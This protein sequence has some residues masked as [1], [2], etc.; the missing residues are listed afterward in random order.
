MAVITLLV[1]RACLGF[2]LPGR[3]TIALLLGAPLGFV[4]GMPFPRG[5]RLVMQRSS[6]LGGREW[7]LHRYWHSAGSNPRHGD[8]IPNRSAGG[9]CLLLR[10]T[11]GSHVAGRHFHRGPRDCFATFS[12]NRLNRLILGCDALLG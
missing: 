10:R 12:S 11:S 4:L 2:T 3:T 7:F 5:L 9:V 8:G 6:A 1:F